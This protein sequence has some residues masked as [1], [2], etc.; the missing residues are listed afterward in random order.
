MFAGS[1]YPD[2]DETSP[3]PAEAV[4]E[5]DAAAA[6]ECAEKVMTWAEKL[7]RPRLTWQPDAI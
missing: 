5:R 3:I 6:L 4:D 7:L 2:M 1:R